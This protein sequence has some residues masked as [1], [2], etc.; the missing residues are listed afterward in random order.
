MVHLKDNLGEGYYEIHQ[1]L[2]ERGLAVRGQMVRPFK[3]YLHDLYLESLKA[4]GSV[5]PVE[6]PKHAQRAIRNL[7][8]AKLESNVT[9]TSPSESVPKVFTSAPHASKLVARI[10]ALKKAEE[11]KRKALAEEPTSESSSSSKSIVAAFKN[12]APKDDDASSSKSDPDSTSSDPP[13]GPMLEPF[14]R[15]EKQTY[16]GNLHSL[17]G[18]NGDLNQIDW[19]SLDKGG[20]APAAVPEPKVDVAKVLKNARFAN[21]RVLGSCTRAFQACLK[22]NGRYNLARR[23]LCWQEDGNRK[24]LE[25]DHSHLIGIQNRQK[26]RY[27]AI[28]NTKVAVPRSLVSVWSSHLPGISDEYV[29]AESEVVPPVVEDFESRVFDRSFVKEESSKVSSTEDS[30]EEKSGP[31]FASLPADS[32]DEEE[33]LNKSSASDATVVEDL[34]EDEKPSVKLDSSI[35]LREVGSTASKGPNSFLTSSSKNYVKEMMQNLSSIANVMTD[36]DSDDESVLRSGRSTRT[37]SISAEDK[38]ENW[39]EEDLNEPC[40]M[41][42][43]HEPRSGDVSDFDEDKWDIVGNSLNFLPEHILQQLTKNQKAVLGEFKG[44]EGKDIE[45]DVKAAGGT[46][47]IEGGKVEVKEEDLE[48]VISDTIEDDTSTLEA[49]F[50]SNLESDFDP[51]PRDQDERGNKVEEQIMIDRTFVPKGKLRSLQSFA[52]QRKSMIA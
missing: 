24:N 32:S 23:E 45:K 30:S 15:N 26:S 46:V 47:R 20:A 44:E 49:S 22:L 42:Y 13:Q 39:D 4:K 37:N 41:R 43:E 36:L 29:V 16:F 1:H 10:L 12:V 5:A 40:Y 35:L 38:P 14:L 28:E 34:T 52:Q 9:A 27:K 50:S 6:L 2:L 33:E 51:L 21:N 48:S 25:I 17:C 31:R 7:K 18:G 8:L 3:N 11:E 19:D